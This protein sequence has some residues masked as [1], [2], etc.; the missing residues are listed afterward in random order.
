[1]PD[2]PLDS[3]TTSTPPQTPTIKVVDLDEGFC[4][5]SVSDL[6]SSVDESLLAPH[7]TPPQ[8][9]K[10]WRGSGGNQEDEASKK[11]Q[12]EHQGDSTSMTRNDADIDNEVSYTSRA[13]YEE[14]RQWRIQRSQAFD[15]VNEWFK[16]SSMESVES[17]VILAS[18]RL[19]DE[20]G[21]EVARRRN[22]SYV[23]RTRRR[24]VSLPISSPNASKSLYPS[25][26]GL[27]INTGLERLN[28]RTCRDDT[29]LNAE[30]LTYEKTYSGKVSINYN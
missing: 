13:T 22:R 30:E 20:D 27:A 9:P 25:T 18:Y 29:A 17:T 8:T 4:C 23:Q 1:M 24:A 16:Q 11:D 5:M 2:A 28:N 15:H 26:M 7:Y 14:R 21:I 19:E 6:D 10:R 12:Y 3:M